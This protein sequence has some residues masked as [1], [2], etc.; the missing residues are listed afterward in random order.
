MPTAPTFVS[1]YEG[2][3][4]N[5][6][7]SPKTSAPT[8]ATGDVLA[9]IGGTEEQNQT[10]LNTPT[11]GGLTYNLQQSIAV[12]A[13]STAYAWTA[14]A[15]S[16]QSFTLSLTDTGATGWWG[17]NCL[18]FSG[19]AGVGASAKNNASGAP[20]LDITTQANSAIVVIVLDWNALDGTGH[21]WRTGAGVMTEQTY[22]TGTQ[23]TVYAGFHADSGAA[24][25]KTVG[26]TAPAG[27][28]F[29][30]IALEILGSSTTPVSD[31][32]Q[33]RTRMGALI[34]L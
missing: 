7:T 31:V 32:P 12:S 8:V 17:F 29:S 6:T 20:T 1:E 18:R 22:F 11:G 14:L 33:R 5:N 3:A 19:S 10:L 26:L 34:Q 27:E 13:F 9:I 23:Y 28:K 30:I 2:P 25:L 21:V 4:W 24:G 16:G 15:G